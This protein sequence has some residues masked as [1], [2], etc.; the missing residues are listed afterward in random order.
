VSL[1]PKIYRLATVIVLIVFLLFAG[2]MGYLY[3]TG[4]KVPTELQTAVFTAFAG[5]IGLLINQKPEGPN[6]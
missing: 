1:D 6:V 5:L 3:A 2:V 4:Q